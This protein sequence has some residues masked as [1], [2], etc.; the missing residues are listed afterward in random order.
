MQMDAEIMET[1]V[2]C[3]YIFYSNPAKNYEC[4]FFISTLIVYKHSRIKKQNRRGKQD[5]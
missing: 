2:K 3:F 4:I 5:N 1:I